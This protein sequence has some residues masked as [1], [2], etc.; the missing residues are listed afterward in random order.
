MLVYTIGLAEHVHI[1]WYICLLAALTIIWYIVGGFIAHYDNVFSDQ[2]DALNESKAITTLNASKMS[3]LVIR[4]SQIYKENGTKYTIQVNA[5]NPMER[6]AQKFQFISPNVLRHSTAVAQLNMMIT[7]CDE[8]LDKL[9][10]AED[11][12]TFKKA[13]E[14]LERFVKTSIADIDFL[15]NTMRR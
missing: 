11:N 6:L 2:Q 13:E 14:K 5:K 7:T 4:C 3:Q 8:L 10:S 12:E 15:K 9:E 1:K